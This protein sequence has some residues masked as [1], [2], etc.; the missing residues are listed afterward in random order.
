[1]NSNILQL[2]RLPDLITILTALFG[3]TAILSVLNNDVDGAAI[4]ILAAALADGVD[5]AVARYIESG[6]FGKYL[7][8]FADA[9]SFGVAPAIIYYV[10]ISAHHH[11]L[12]CAISAAYLI[13]GM[14]RLARFN[15]A[16]YPE[17]RGLPITAAGTS[18]VLLLY[19]IDDIYYSEYLVT[20]V[21]AILSILM[22]SDIRYP[23]IRS[24]NMLIPLAA[25]FI[26]TIVAYYAGFC[27]WF[28]WIL[29][30]LIG[31]YTMSPLVGGSRI[32]GD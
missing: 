31:I 10:V 4:L 19:L 13:C 23:K 29:F 24:L 7:D 22:I 5:G 28:A 11:T 9:V 18:A 15:I 25:I 14:L 20:G 32:Y 6:V 30:V 21:F 17:F 27:N 1:M 16:D 8:S 12:V 2:I 3:F 26:L